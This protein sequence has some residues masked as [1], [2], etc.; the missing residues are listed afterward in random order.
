MN[1][2]F[3]LILLIFFFHH[4]VFG[5]ANNDFS[6]KVNLSC[7]ITQGILPIDTN[8]KKFILL[9]VDKDEAK[10]LFTEDKASLYKLPL[11]RFF[12][13][14]DTVTLGWIATGSGSTD[15]IVI[16][17]KTGEFIR[18]TSGNYFTGKNTLLE[19]DIQKGKCQ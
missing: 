17:K 11:H 14:K 4:N 19:A 10:L 12:D 13:S 1:T 6:A 9:D 8:K 7:E 2:R 16:N 5:Q 18:T 15:I 3:L